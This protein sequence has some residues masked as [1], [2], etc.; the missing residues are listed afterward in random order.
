MNLNKKVDLNKLSCEQVMKR[1]D[2]ILEEDDKSL[3]NMIK[4]LNKGRDMMKETNKQ[5]YKQME[6]MD[7][8]NQELNEMDGSLNRTKKTI[9]YMNKIA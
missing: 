4:T 9:S 3:Q 8:I 5:L 6:D 7:R 2:K 1:G